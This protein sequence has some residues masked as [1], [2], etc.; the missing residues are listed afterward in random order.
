MPN[1]PCLR[2]DPFPLEPEVIS[3]FP[4]PGSLSSL[5]RLIEIDPKTDERPP[6]PRIQAP[7]ALGEK[8][9]SFAVVSGSSRSTSAGQIDILLPIDHGK[10]RERLSQLSIGK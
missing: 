5:Q 3:P 9:Q 7:K 4:L 6:L 10:L 8:P 2:P 1:G